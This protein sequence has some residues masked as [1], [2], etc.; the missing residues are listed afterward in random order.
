MNMVNSESSVTKFYFELS[1]N[2]ISNV[3]LLLNP[4]IF[5]EAI[6]IPEDKL[7]FKYERNSN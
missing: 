7:R 3:K 2:L 6:T 5:H 1:G 4:L